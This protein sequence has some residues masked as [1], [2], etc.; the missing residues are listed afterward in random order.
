MRNSSVLRRVVAAVALLSTLAALPACHSC[1]AQ[2]EPE[3]D[4]VATTPA[5]PEADAGHRPHL[6]FPRRRHDGGRL[7][8]FH[9]AGTAAEP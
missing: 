3:P 1:G 2:P 5:A 9:D 6:Q 8:D 7:F 4:P